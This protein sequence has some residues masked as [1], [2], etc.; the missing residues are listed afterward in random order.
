M[1]E[2]VRNQPLVQNIVTDKTQETNLEDQDVDTDVMDIM[3]DMLE[4]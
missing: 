2:P 3:S 1:Y 4:T